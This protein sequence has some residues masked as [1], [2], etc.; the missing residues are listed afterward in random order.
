MR[1][2]AAMESVGAVEE[3]LRSNEFGSRWPPIWSVRNRI[4]HGY[5][6]VDRE[7]ITSTV[8]SDLVEFEMSIDRMAAVARG[9]EED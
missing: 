4:A 2:S 6:Y 9:A 3:G 5:F 8:T 7:I 1:L